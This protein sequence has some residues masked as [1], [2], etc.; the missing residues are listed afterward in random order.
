M[1][2]RV[3][4]YAKQKHIPA[5]FLMKFRYLI[6]RE[7][8]IRRTVAVMGTVLRNS[9]WA[10][11]SYTNINPLQYSFDLNHYFHL[12]IFLFTTVTFFLLNLNN[13]FLINL[14]GVSNLWWFIGADFSDWSKMFVELAAFIIPALL[15]LGINISSNIFLFSTSANSVP[16]WLVANSTITTPTNLVWD[17][18]DLKIWSTLK[19]QLTTTQ[20]D[21][22]SEFQLDKS[23][24]KFINYELEYYLY[25]T[26]SLNLSNTRP[27]LTETPL[28]FTYPQAYELLKQR[29][30]SSFSKKTNLFTPLTI[31][32]TNSTQSQYF[33]FTNTTYQHLNLWLKESELINLSTNLNWQGQVSNS[34]RWAYR[35]NNLHRRS[36]Y[37]SHKLTESKKLLSGGYFDSSSTLNNLWFSDQYAR[38]LTFK[39]RASHL[40]SLAQIRSNWNLLYRSVFSYSHLNNS[41]KA[42]T[43]LSSGDV[44]SRLSCYESSFHFFLNR[45]K[46][47][48]LLRNHTIKSLPRLGTQVE[49]TAGNFNNLELLYSTTLNGVLKH[50]RGNVDGLTNFSNFFTTVYNTCNGQHQNSQSMATRDLL[51]V[52]QDKDLLTYHTNILFNLTNNL[53]TRTFYYTI[54][55]P[56]VG[57]ELLPTQYNTKILK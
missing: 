57:L 4:N 26:L 28:I 11:K 29:E 14:F 17:N 31:Y 41:F 19:C 9:K 54:T 44:F 40:T 20:Y 45:I 13:I 43:T 34:L 24:A 3:Y 36:I 10:D 53:T 37:N 18:L 25:N 35:Y 33:Y 2:I 39:K 6:E 52:S 16:S 15:F 22:L 55:L 23:E 50:E 27:L 32:S 47:F 8:K 56:M 1:F 30:Q 48:S 12:F 38:D 42:T 21:L 7:G 51:L 49:S 5:S 46:F